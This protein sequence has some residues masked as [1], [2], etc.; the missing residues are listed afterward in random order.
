M[1]IDGDL[2]TQ[3]KPISVDHF[4]TLFHTVLTLSPKLMIVSLLLA[5]TKSCRNKSSTA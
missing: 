3:S 2:D 5:G 1:I 4:I